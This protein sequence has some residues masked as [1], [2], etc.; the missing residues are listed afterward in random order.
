M[1]GA[2]MIVGSA[3]YTTVTLFCLLSS[4]LTNP[5]LTPIQL[6]KEKKP[7]RPAGDTLASDR[8]VDPEA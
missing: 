4:P 6:T 8:N 3:I 5:I 1:I 2:L 7:E